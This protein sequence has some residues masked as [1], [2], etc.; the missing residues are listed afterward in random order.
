MRA[1]QSSERKMSASE[2]PSYGS[3]S[4][5]PAKRLSVSQH[6]MR[7]CQMIRPPD[8]PKQT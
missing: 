2:R 8:S 6:W 4:A 7:G 1:E 5:S 3:G